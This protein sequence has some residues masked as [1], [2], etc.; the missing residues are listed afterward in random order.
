MMTCPQLRCGQELGG[1]N[2]YVLAVFDG[3]DRSH[4]PFRKP[5]GIEGNAGTEKATDHDCISCWC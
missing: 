1:K 5:T 4:L 3:A 2:A